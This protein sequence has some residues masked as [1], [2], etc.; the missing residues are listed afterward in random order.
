MDSFMSED[1]S[2]KNEVENR[3]VLNHFTYM[4]MKQWC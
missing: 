1:R 4:Y 2:S 3:G